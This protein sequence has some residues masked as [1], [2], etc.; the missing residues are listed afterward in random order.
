MEGMELLCFQIIS[1]NGAANPIIWK[2]FRKRKREI[3]KLPSS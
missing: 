3:L 2:R 1:A